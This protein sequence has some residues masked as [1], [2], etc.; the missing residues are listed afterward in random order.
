MI[1]TIKRL[2]RDVSASKRSTS[3]REQILS[4]RCRITAVPTV[5]IEKGPQI[6]QLSGL[7]DEQTLRDCS[8]YKIEKE[9]GLEEPLVLITYPV[10]DLST[11]HGSRDPFDPAGDLKSLAIAIEC[12]VEPNSWEELR[13]RRQNQFNGKDTDTRD[14]Q[15]PAST[16]KFGKCAGTPP[17]RQTR[18]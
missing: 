15:T 18:T 10:G 11:E 4:K 13:R 2:E 16:G 1:P 6:V 14:W 3:P 12:A 7:R 17:S 9:Q 5:L 8:W